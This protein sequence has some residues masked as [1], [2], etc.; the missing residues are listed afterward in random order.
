MFAEP[1]ILPQ[2]MLEAK[3]PKRAPKKRAA[4]KANRTSKRAPRG[5][6]HP[7]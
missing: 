3:K 7:R 5:R 4:N 2:E 1:L 6:A